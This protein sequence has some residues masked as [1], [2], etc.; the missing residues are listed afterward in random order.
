VFESGDFFAH[1]SVLPDPRVDRTRKHNLIDILFIAICTV[2]CGG[3]GFNDMEE[4]GIAKED[5][6]KRFLELPN[7]IPS[8]DT[9]RAVISRIDPQDFAECFTNWTAAIHEMTEG[10]VIALDGKTLRH[11]FDK[12]TGQNALHIVSAWATGS[13]VAL[14]QI[15]VDEKSN[16]I[17]AI[18][19][20]LELL[21]IKGCIVTIDA[22]GC[23]KDIAEMIIGKGG[24]YVLCL[25][26][27][28]SGLHDDVKWFFEEIERSG[29][30]DLEHRYFESVE[31]DHGRI[32]IRKCWMVEAD[33]IAWLG[34]QG[35]AWKGLKSLAAIKSERRTGGK[36]ATETRY[37]I[38]SL[39]GSAEQLASAA[40]GHWGIENSLHYVLDVT[41]NEDKNRIRKDNA[42]ENL[43]ILRK[44]A[45]NSIKRE[46]SSAKSSVRV[47]I[48]K[49]GWDNSYLEK[50]L[51]G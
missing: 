32:E 23:Q 36:I 28:Q 31:K 49:A 5:W 25:K 12:A 51:V 2:I 21:E 14:G 47:R 26:G 9:F 44:I 3:E 27:N 15:R 37:F 19:K 6:L 38:S 46:T 18:P 43:A 24:D 10:E 39:T 42:P 48:K 30:G 17:T 11:S 35:H 7:G 4:F 33:A 22:M 40:R 50:I 20:L 45:I 16:E 1:F 29:F 34:E 8:H 13:G 41:M